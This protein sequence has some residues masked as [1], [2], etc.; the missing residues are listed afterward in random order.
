MSS[1]LETT[2]FPPGAR[3]GRAPL[4][5][6]A[7]GGS[8][9]APPVTKREDVLVVDLAS[10]DAAWCGPK[11]AR[12]GNLVA[13]GYRVPAG[14]VLTTRVQD[15][16]LR[17]NRLEAR[18]ALWAETAAT[19]TPAELVAMAAEVETTLAAAV[20]PPVV[21]ERLDPWLESLGDH[22]FA[23]RSSATQ[24]DL[25]GATFAGLYHTTLDVEPADVPRQVMR[26]HASLFA[27]RAALYRR[28]KGLT[29][30][31]SMAVI[32]QRMVA[33]EVAG[34]V[35][36]RAPGAPDQLLIECAPGLGEALVSGTVTP[37]RYRIRHRDQALVEARE[38]HTIDRRQVLEVA[39][40]A[41]RIEEQ[42]A[43]AVDLELAIAEGEI[44][45]LQARPVAVAG[46]GAAPRG[47]V[48]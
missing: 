17:H 31:G 10:A 46:G 16:V 30:I 40:L 38:V 6:A 26:C 27:A 7:E 20:W 22:R 1:E 25:A 44:A 12:L 18:A 29:G 37:N 34:V 36:T 43:M 24:E 9:A 5:S 39:R 21:A 23:V 11:A 41:V 48:S 13:R 32:V 3:A 4:A 45:W 35:Y 15:E 14:I 47:M 19:A 42:L 8:I 2:V 28:R 33:S